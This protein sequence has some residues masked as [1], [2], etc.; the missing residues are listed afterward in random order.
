[1][2][3]RR[4]YATSERDHREWWRSVLLST[5]NE[6]LVAYWDACVKFLAR[7][8]V[9]GGSALLLGVDERLNVPGKAAPLLLDEHVVGG[10][11]A[12]GGGV[13]GLAAGG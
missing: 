1:M 9:A 4:V 7:C 6:E 2:F 13:A 12:C 3:G 10:T 11:D 5:Q 8:G